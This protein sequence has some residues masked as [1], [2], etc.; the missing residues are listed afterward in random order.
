MATADLPKSEEFPTNSFKSK[1]G[2][3]HEPAPEKKVEPLVLKG[4][5]T[6]R[7]K[8]LGAKFKE[9]FLGADARDVGSY[10]LIDV[11]IPAAKSLIYDMATQGMNRALY[12]DS[13]P[14]PRSGS[15]NGRYVSYNRMSKPTPPWED[16]PRTLSRQSRATHSFDD[17]PFTDRED[18]TEALERL[19]MLVDQFDVAT[20]TDFYELVGITGSFTDNKW[21]WNSLRDARV[22]PSRD[23]FII[24]LPRPIPLD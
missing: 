17:L 2:A 7:K 16:S 3:R 5:V 6:Q 10:L 23:G 24:D 15:S 4:L 21:G 8:P 22:L 19:R 11:A 14:S 20:V 13:R 18:A 9:L 12:G 1:E